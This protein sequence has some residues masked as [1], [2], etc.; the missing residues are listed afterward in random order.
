M[1][2]VN[3]NKS[4]T[5]LPSESSFV[6][7]PNSSRNSS[8]SSSIN[9]H[10]FQSKQQSTPINKKVRLQFNF[11]DDYWYPLASIS[12]WNHYTRTTQNAFNPWEL[13]KRYPN[14]VKQDKYGRS[15]K[16]PT[17]APINE[18]YINQH[19]GILKKQSNFHKKQKN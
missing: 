12:N 4:I 9:Q 13:L 3:V 8:R 6:S 2:N 15:N 1:V 7:T 18:D 10:S 19:K 11:C 16:A 5:D 14:Y 17:M